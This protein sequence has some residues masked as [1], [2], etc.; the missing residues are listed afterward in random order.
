MSQYIDIPAICQ[1]IG[2]IY[3]NPDILDNADYKFYEEDFTE[4]IHKVLFGSIYNLYALGTKEITQNVI[5]SYLEQKP[6]SYAIYKANKGGELLEKMRLACEP[7]TFNYYYK[8]MKK[9]TL[10][11]MYNEIGL[12]LKWL[13]DIDNIIDIKKKQAQEEWVDNTPIEEI[14]EIIDNKI[15]N[16]RLKYAEDNEE[17]GIQAGKGAKDL[18]ENLRK[19]PEFGSPMFGPLIN[20]VTRGARLGKLYIR[21]AATGVGKTRSMIADACYLS[22]DRIYNKKDGSWEELLTQEPTLFITTEQEI[23]EIQTMMLAFIADVEEDHILTGEYESGE[24]ERIYQAAEILEKAPIFI[25]QMPDF[26]LKDI[27]STIKRNMRDNNVKYICFDYLHSSMKI[28]SEVSSKSGVKGLRED[29]VLF[30][31]A[32]RLKDL[33]VQNN[34]FIITATQLNGDYVNAEIYDQN[35]LR[36]AK[37]I[38][39]KVDVGMI[40]LD[41]TEKDKE[42]LKELCQKTGCPMPD[43]KISIYKVRRGKYKGILLWSAARKGVCRIEP[44]FATNYGFELINIADTKIKIRKPVTASAF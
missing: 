14:A 33:C 43:V 15:T 22:C 40:M 17:G 3:I 39:D 29:N 36:G 10:F 1:V 9:M 26:S 11:R 23:D 21:S 38:A 7:K 31:I 5:E 18:I 2:N 37:A 30:M 13:Y 24:Y 32:I 41:V 34:I 6:N 25:E 28:L 20:T 4:D 19:N 16:I 12:D 42:M 44:M 35:L 8:R 27:E